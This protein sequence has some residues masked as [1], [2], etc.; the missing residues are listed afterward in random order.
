MG[1]L[2]VRAKPG[3]GS[4]EARVRADFKLGLDDTGP[5]PLSQRPVPPEA[6]DSRLR[7][8]LVL[9]TRPSNR[10]TARP[11]SSARISDSP[12]RI[13]ETPQLEA[14]RHQPAYGFH[15]RSPL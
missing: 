3:I 1:A 5:V 9:G 15:F 8:A 6:S 4:K 12:T 11:M 14:G 10:S 2:R 13:A 7:P